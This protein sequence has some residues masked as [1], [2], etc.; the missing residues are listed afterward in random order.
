MKTIKANV[1]GC[2]S[3]CV[4]QSRLTRRG[5]LGTV[6]AFPPEK[7]RLLPEFPIPEPPPSIVT[8]RAEGS[9]KLLHACHPPT[10]NLKPWAQRCAVCPRGA[11]TSGDL[12]R[13]PPHTCGLGWRPP[14]P[15]SCCL[16]AVETIHPYGLREQIPDTCTWN[17]S[18]L[19]DD[20]FSLSHLLKM[21]YNTVGSLV[22]AAAVTSKPCS[23]FQIPPHVSVCEADPGT[24]CH[25][26]P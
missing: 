22:K 18:S 6:S 20:Y 9:R 21:W 3:A 17:S 16:L 15:Q 1:K 11:G 2:S 4:P 8:P 26:L 25:S 24:A 19:R 13:A 5:L 7:S 23:L 12:A 14:P 10:Q